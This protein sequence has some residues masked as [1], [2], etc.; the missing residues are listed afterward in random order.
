MKRDFDEPVV[1]WSC[2]ANTSERISLTRERDSVLWDTASERALL[3]LD[4]SDK[5]CGYSQ[6]RALFSPHDDQILSDGILWDLRSGKQIY[7]FDKL[8]NKI[9][10]LFNTSGREIII[11]SEGISY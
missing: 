2:F 3:T 4:H 7:R 11:N 1:T 6:N 10:G 8:N 9:S 5:G